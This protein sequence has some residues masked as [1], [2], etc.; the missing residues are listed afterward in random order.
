MENKVCECCFGQFVC[1]VHKTTC[2]E[3]DCVLTT[4]VKWS[5]LSQMP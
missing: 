5:W 2:Y 3:S 4:A 1:I